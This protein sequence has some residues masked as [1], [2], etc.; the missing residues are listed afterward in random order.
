MFEDTLSPLLGESADPVAAGWQLRQLAESAVDRPQELLSE[1]AQASKKLAVSD[2]AILG[3]LLRVLHTVLLEAGRET[4][5]TADPGGLISIHQSL[6]DE[7]PNRHLLLQMLAMIHSQAS[8]ELLVAALND[9]PPT[10]W[11][12]AAQVL[13]PL[14]QHKGW[15]VNAFFPAA[16]DCMQHAVLASPLLDLA[17]YV[18]RT[19]ELEQHPAAERLTMLNHL[20]G[21]VSGRLSKFEDNPR[22]FGDDVDTVHAMLG[23]AV[24]LA[25]SLCDTVGLIGDESSIGKLNQTVELRHRRVQCEAA[26]ALAKLGDDLGQKRLLELTADPAARLRAIAYADELEIGELVDPA[27]RTDGATAEAEMALWLSQPQQ[28][29]VPPTDIEM[30]ETRRLLW[31][32]FTDPVGVFLVRFEYNFGD[33]TYSNVGITGP[34]TFAMSTDVA[35]LPME[36]IFAIYAGW[37]A[38]HPEIFAV[39][40]DQFNDAQTR[41]MGTYQKHLGQV[42]YESV[43]PAL[44]GFFLDEQAGI[45][46]AV[47][48]ATQCVVVTDG[49]ETI[50][51]PTAGRLRP[52][53]PGDLF[54]L[55]KGRKMLRTFNPNS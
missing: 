19:N 13:S 9:N 53:S 21:E 32:S 1:M 51:H 22:T 33:R 31:P 43:K 27:H 28:M 10:K 12:E 29:G 7:T 26:G 36:D 45:F 23:E 30:I 17:N 37:H 18:F 16:L 47:R 44:L 5:E 6:P 25:V 4:M 2:P 3:G 38:D 48:D 14:M 55:Y 50:D 34:V 8:L 42:G 20:L 24:A 15:P 39:A 11:V 52:L 54:N 35:N 41:I 46:T 40:A 49:L